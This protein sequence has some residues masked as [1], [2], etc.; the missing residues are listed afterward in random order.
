MNIVMIPFHDRKKWLSEGYRTRDAHLFQHFEKNDCVDKILVV[1][2]PVSAAERLLKHNGGICDIDKTEYQKKGVTLIRTGDKSWCVDIKLPD[3]AKVAVQKKMWWFTAFQYSKTID[4]INE[5]LE[6]LKMENNILLLQNPM[7]IGAAKAVKHKIFV[8][9]AI[10]NWIYHPQMKYKDLI[11]KNYKYVEENA[12]LITTVSKALTETFGSNKNTHWVPNGVDV[13]YFRNAVSVHKPVKEAVIGYVG[14]I[15]DRVDFE[16][17]E[18]CLKEMPECKFVFLGPAY[19]QQSTIE[20]LKRNY[21]NILFKGDIH[22]SV[23]PREM[24]EFDVAII[25]HKIDDFTSSMNPLKLYEYLAAGKPVVT[26][27]V[28]GTD[29]LS[30]F[31]YSAVGSDEFVSQLRKAV[32][33][34]SDGSTD[35]EDII[36]SIPE[37]CHWEKRVEVILGLFSKTFFS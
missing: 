20:K 19:S 27:A 29:H 3:F 26:T 24:Q 11:K 34:V 10:D 22:Y 1:N 16:L 25:P 21:G 13:D 28:A 9:D 18:K 12:D 31:V 33:V 2:R 30:E 23:L 5:A 17:V 14:K 35:V 7:A 4:A 37:E 6:Y 36:R 32:S 8:F 15:Q